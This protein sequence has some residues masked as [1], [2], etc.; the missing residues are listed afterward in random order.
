MQENT[1]FRKLDLLPSSGD[2]KEAPALLGPLERA[3]LTHRSSWR[4]AL[5][6][7]SN[8]EGVFPPHLRT[9]AGPVSETLRFLHLEL[10]TLDIV[11]E[12]IGSD[13]S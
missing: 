11:Q 2:G 10:L 3:S 1:A 5:S 9:E 7:G 4:E 12:A 13:L 8:R 6:R